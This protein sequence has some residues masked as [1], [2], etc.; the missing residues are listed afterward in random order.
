MPAALPMAA[1]VCALPLSY[2]LVG[3]IRDFASYLSLLDF[4]NPRSSHAVPTP[5]RGGAGAAVA[6]LSILVGATVLFASDWRLLLALL[7]V[8]VTTPRRALDPRRYTHWG[9][10]GIR[11]QLLDI[12][13]RRLVADFHVEGDGR[14]MHVLNAVSPAFTSSIPCASYVIDR[15]QA[16]VK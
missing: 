3:V 11:A 1:G 10:P 12:R 13:T 16:E 5:R 4:P 7:G 9:K 14:A 8:A 2:L 6:A 15:I